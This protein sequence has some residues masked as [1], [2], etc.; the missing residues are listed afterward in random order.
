MAE[1][2]TLLTLADSRLPTGGHVHSGGVEEAITSGLVVNL[3]GLDAFLRRRIRTHGL[4]TASIAAAVHR[5]QLTAAQADRETDA[6]TPAPA[7]RAASRSQGRGLTRL[8]RRVWPAADWDDL[9]RQ[10]HLGVVAGRVGAVSGLT[11]GHSA[12]S[13]VY[14]TM[15]GT[16][17]A[18]QRLLALDPADVAALTFGLS[19]M[20]ERTAA[21]ATGALAE[22]S[23]PL[24]D[25]L[26]ERHAKRERPLFVS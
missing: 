7:A 20:C 24:L 14:T 10:P 12:L 17:T 19:D 2:S 5:G 15:T 4:V 22:L 3:A 16:A 25:E 23:D 9:G 8:A 11:P 1:L 18:A 26:A 21:E 13:I 6:R